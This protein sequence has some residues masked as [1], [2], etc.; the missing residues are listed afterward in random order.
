MATV[1]ILLYQSLINTKSSPNIMNEV[2][3]LSLL[4]FIILHLY[5]LAELK[6]QSTHVQ[7]KKSL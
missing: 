5:G 4:K 3:G 1:G 6:M 2:G 7:G